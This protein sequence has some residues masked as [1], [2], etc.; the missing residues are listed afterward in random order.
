MPNENE[1][2][3]HLP[4]EVTDPAALPDPVFTLPGNGALI[5]SEATGNTYRIGELIGEGN[6]G[7]VY[8]CSD[9]WENELA[10]KILKPKGTYDEVRAAAVAEFEKLK[11]LRHPNITFVF[12]A[13]EFQ[14]TFYIV[15][16]MCWKPINEFMQSEGFNG[17]VWLRPIARQL[18][19]AVHYI[20]CNHFAHQDIHGGNVFIQAARDDLSPNDMIFTYMLGDL[21]LAKLAAEMDAENT[22]LADW[23]RAPESINPTEFGPMDHRMDIYHCGL[24]FLQILLG[25]PH[26][27]SREEVLAGAPREL[28]LTL[29][30]PYNFALEKSLRRHV[31]FRTASALE[32][33]RDLN[34]PA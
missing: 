12:D 22:V 24:L 31:D 7:Y 9:T 15:C 27:F 5:T 20:H 18:L 14:H 26:T 33:W 11:L 16:E 34:T 23:M 1:Q 32:F 21:G 13:F 17:R 28:A 25:R 30:A 10:V 4:V 2:I 3:E 29:E 6:F 8:R 19:Q